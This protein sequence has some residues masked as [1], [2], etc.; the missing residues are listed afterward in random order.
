[1]M[2]VQVKLTMIQ[3]VV[4]APIQKAL[5]SLSAGHQTSYMVIIAPIYKFILI[6]GLPLR[7]RNLVQQR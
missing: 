7:S 6:Y 5:Q 1:M 2:Y 4:V 3:L